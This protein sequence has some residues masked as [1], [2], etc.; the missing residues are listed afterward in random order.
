MWLYVGR[1]ESDCMH[2]CVELACVYC[3]VCVA[4]ECEMLNKEC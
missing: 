4:I 1:R 3:V 2:S